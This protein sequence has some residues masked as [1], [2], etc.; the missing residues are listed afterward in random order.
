[1]GDAIE[2]DLLMILPE[3]DSFLGPGL[4]LLQENSS[5]CAEPSLEWR[6]QDLLSV[7]LGW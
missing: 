4:D 6:P 7:L 3:P 2:A 5:V 1:M